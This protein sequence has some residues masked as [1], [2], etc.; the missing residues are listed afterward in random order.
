MTSLHPSSPKPSSPKPSPRPPR[1]IAL[2]AACPFPTS[3]GS[4]VFIH[5]LACALTSA[6]HEVHVVAYGFGEYAQETPYR[7]H[8][9]PAWVPSR[10]LRAG[11]SL[12]KPLLDA[13]LALRLL[14]VCRRERIEVIHAVNYEAAFVGAAARLF[15]RVPVVY[16]AHGL[17]A[18]ELPNYFDRPA[19]R[20]LAATAGRII[21]RLLL[22]C[23]QAIVTLT[24]HDA[25]YLRARA[26]SSPAVTT[27]RPGIAVP[28]DDAAAPTPPVE[29]PPV[30]VY[31][32]NL[33][34]YQGLD[35]V[36]AAFAR[37]VLRFP[38]ARL[39]V[40]TSSDAA[41][42]AAQA[43]RLGIGGRVTVLAGLPFAE[44]TA[45]IRAATIA[46]VPRSVA[47]GFPIKLLNY[48][49]LGVPVILCCR[50]YDGI[51]DGENAVLC[52]RTAEAFAEAMASL[53]GDPERR[54]R[55][56]AAARRT[57]DDLYR[58]D[59]AVRRIEEVYASVL[60]R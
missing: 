45:A 56:A 24:E 42:L 3:Q 52:G 22:R 49:A 43:A 31:A 54:A 51:G 19:A 16:H 2:V 33:D 21:E 5:Q 53:A 58:W 8:R 48:M 46:L 14:G 12:W 23:A 7:V 9:T 55:L 44:T 39:V 37:V 17:L 25:A 13:L 11:P 27:I 59:D 60:G 57:G 4:Q 18:M 41:P 38:G 36:L 50:E 6:G 29:A 28:A 30:F 35:V 34:R 1:R 47:Y 10:K 32:G 20:R 26:R 15:L 40:T